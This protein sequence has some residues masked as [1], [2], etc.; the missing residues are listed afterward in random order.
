MSVCL[1]QN[2]LDPAKDIKK[3]VRGQFGADRLVV[4]FPPY[5]SV[6]ADSALLSSGVPW[7]FSFNVKFYPPNPAQL[8]E[9][10]TRYG[11]TS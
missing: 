11:A 8:S 6:S 1:L 4:V 5:L 9:D 3:Q 10:I 2:W 7:N